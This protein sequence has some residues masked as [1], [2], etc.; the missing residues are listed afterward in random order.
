MK[1]GVQ[2]KAQE[3]DAKVRALHSVKHRGIRRGIRVP[4][5]PGA[6]NTGYI[7]RSRYVMELLLG[8][9]LEPS[10]LVHHKNEIVDDDRCENLGLTSRGGHNTTHKTKN[11]YTQI[12]YLRG[13][14]LSYSKITAKTGYA[15]SSISYALKVMKGK[16]DAN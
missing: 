8:R 7:L 2:Y 12:A 14:G 3:I 13:R 4:G 6:N 5:H 10:E 16:H 1:I 15:S 9:Y 11:N